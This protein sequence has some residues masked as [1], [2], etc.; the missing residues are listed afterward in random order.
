MGFGSCFLCV[1]SSVVVTRV[2]I[3]CFI[4]DSSFVVVVVFY[5]VM[6][7]C[8][9]FQSLVLYTNECT[10]EGLDPRSLRRTPL[11]RVLLIA[12]S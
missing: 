2:K 8:A 7:D 5:F 11:P 12:T 3:A 10:P 1:D 6:F 9:S 4:F